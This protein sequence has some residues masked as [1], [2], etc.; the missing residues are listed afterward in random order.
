MVCTFDI[1]GEQLDYELRL[2]YDGSVGDHGEYT[3][4][5]VIGGETEHVGHGSSINRAVSRL[6]ESMNDEIMD[7]LRGNVDRS[8]GLGPRARDGDD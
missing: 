7:A 2:T 1:D 6:A 8:L 3:A 4:A 5:F